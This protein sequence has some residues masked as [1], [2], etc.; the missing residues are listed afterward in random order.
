MMIKEFAGKRNDIARD[1]FGPSDLAE[2][3]NV[4]IDDSFKL[5][6]RAG[7]EA[8]FAGNIH[9]LWSDGDIC[10]YVLEDGMYQLHEDMTSTQ[11]SAGLTLDAPMEYL[12]LNGVVYHS[13]GYQRAAV[14]NGQIRGWGMT[15]PRHFNAVNVNG[16]LAPGLYQYSL[17]YIRNDR[18]ES[19]SSITQTVEVVD[20]GIQF[21]DIPVPNDPAIVGKTLYVSTA[22]GELM[23]EVSE[24]YASEQSATMTAH[25]TSV[26]LDTQFMGK[27]PAGQCIAEHYG[28]VLVASG[29]L[30]NY[31]GAYMP[32]LFK[33]LDFIPMPEA[34]TI[35]APV[36][37][38]IFVGTQKRM[39]FISG[40]TPQEFSYTEVAN[41][42][43]IAGTLQMVPAHLMGF[44]G[45]SLIALWTSTKG[46]CAGTPDGT[47]YNLTGGRF[48]QNITAARGASTVRKARD[49]YQ[50]VASL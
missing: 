5:S 22:D 45:E 40:R 7:S 17:T 13:N 1:R 18:Q 16:D 21:S 37:N 28:H 32:E 11:L 6:R 3:T 43:A 39:G 30:L 41:Y 42:G 10:L 8:L 47:I 15:P 24:L 26:P 46:P 33:P 36:T 23:Y 2:A 35:I 48:D 19:G 20:G 34:I 9:S 49:S 14:V 12:S 25:I 27:P 29:E 44:E 50:Y 38:G 31:S 4:D